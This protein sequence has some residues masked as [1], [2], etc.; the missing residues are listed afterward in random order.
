MGSSAC[1]NNMTNLCRRTKN[2]IIYNELYLEE[3]ELDK[4]NYNKKIIL[5][6]SSIRR[7]LIIRKILSKNFYQIKEISMDY[8]TESFENN[9]IIKKLNDL[10]PKFE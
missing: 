7:F 4:N 2:N 10:L 9:I 1:I 5:I 3:N 8:N 6:Q